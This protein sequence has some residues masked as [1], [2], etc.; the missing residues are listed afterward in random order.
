MSLTSQFNSN[1]PINTGY[2][3]EHPYY[4]IVF[5]STQYIDYYSSFNGYLIESSLPTLQLP[6]D[7]TYSIITPLSNSY[8]SSIS[9]HSSSTTP[10]IYDVYNVEDYSTNE[11]IDNTD[12][13][14]DLYGTKTL[15]INTRFSPFEEPAKYIY[16]TSIMIPSKVATTLQ[17]ATPKELLKAVHPDEQTA[18]ELC[19]LYVSQLTSTHFTVLD[20]TTPDG[21]KPLKSE[22]LRNILSYHPSTYKNAR[23]ALTYPLK[24]GAIIEYI[25]KS[26]VGIESFKHRL[27][28]AYL[29]KGIVP[30]QLQSKVA[31]GCLNNHHF[32]R[33]PELEQNPIIRNLITLYPYIQLP[34]EKQLVAEAKRLCSKNIQYRNSKGKLLTFRHGHKNE[35]WADADNRTFVEDN[36]K[37]YKCLTHDLGRM[38]NTGSPENGFR[39]VDAICLMPKWIRRM[40][41]IKNKYLVECDYNCLHPNIA[42]MLYNGQ[43]HYHTHNK[44]ALAMGYDSE[45]MVKKENLSFFNKT[46]FHMTKSKLYP[47]YKEHEPVMLQNIINDKQDNTEITTKAD[48]HKITSHKMF[49]VE[50]EIITEAIIRLNDMGIFVLYVYDALMCLPEHSN[51]VAEVMDAVALEHGVY[52]NAK[53]SSPRKHNP[54]VENLKDKVFDFSK[55]ITKGNA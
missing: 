18:I 40:I 39:V 50:V 36:I 25:H 41:K 10:L 44:M 32:N 53:Q 30:Y 37:L 7:T 35:R 29:H 23:I 3:T 27:G 48:K 4:S 17:R 45:R 28:S 51:R 13:T 46:P 54:V 8:K 49:R 6:I 12:N 15:Q 52:T 19:I 5:P 26:V 33:L 38:L 47:Y 16:K 20:G 55:I 1:L 2:V 43:N 42:V 21:W 34:T 11:S 31:L 14:A 24:N 22:Y 9:N